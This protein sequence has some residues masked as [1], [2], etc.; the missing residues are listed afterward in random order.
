MRYVA[1]N[2]GAGL[3]AKGPQGINVTAPSQPLKTAPDTQTAA[4]LLS[5][6]A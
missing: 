2:V 5:L 3:L 6:D 4:V 1:K